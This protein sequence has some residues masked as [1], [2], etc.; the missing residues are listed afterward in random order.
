MITIKATASLKRIE[1]AKKTVRLTLFD[2]AERTILFDAIR[3]IDSELYDV[4][5][6][7]DSDA[8]SRIVIEWKRDE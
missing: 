5:L 6:W 4:F 3:K 8:T 7:G 2:Q 1:R